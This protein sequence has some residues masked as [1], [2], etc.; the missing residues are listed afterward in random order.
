MTTK[1]DSKILLD[2]FTASDLNQLRSAVTALT[3]ARCRVHAI[4]LNHIVLNATN[5]KVAFFQQHY[6]LLEGASQILERE[7]QKVLAASL[8]EMADRFVDLQEQEEEHCLA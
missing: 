2:R 8:R 4:G 1:H 7:G 5:P 6:D 3:I